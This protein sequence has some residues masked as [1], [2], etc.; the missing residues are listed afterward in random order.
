MGPAAP[1]DEAIFRSACETDPAM[2]FAT[3]T[4][5]VASLVR[6]APPLAGHEAF[7]AEPTLTL[8]AVLGCSWLALREGV[9]QVRERLAVRRAAVIV[10]SR[11]IE[12]SCELRDR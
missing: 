9:F 7:G 2:I 5:L 10:R 3:V 12:Q 6:L 11:T 4:L 8:A 1:G